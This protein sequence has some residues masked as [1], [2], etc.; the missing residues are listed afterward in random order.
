MK[1]MDLDLY[2]SIPT[3][4]FPLRV[5]LN[6]FR[7]YAFGAHW[8]EHIEIHCIFEGKAVLRCGEEVVRLEA[9]DCAVVNGNEL[10]AGLKGECSYGCLIIPPEIFGDNHV[11]FEHSIRDERLYLM[12]A[13]I[14]EEYKSFDSVRALSIM[15]NA[16]LVIS[17]LINNYSR[18]NLS[19]LGHRRYFEKLEK[20]N[21]AIRYIEDHFTDEVSTGELAEMVH[22]SEG[23]FCHLFKEVT[24]RSAK[25]YMLQL[26]INKA[27]KLIESSSNTI[28]DI[29]YSCGFSDPNYFARVFK[30]KLGCSPSAYKQG[31]L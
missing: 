17:Y 15:G 14:F 31:T 29:C 10:H 25:E 18:E 12:L 23:H 7:S 9:G 5:N 2:E 22:L 13:D 6:R 1:N 4:S 3:K 16:Y 21:K 27:K 30:K 24:G 20:V 8:H 28:T 11:L 26:R 19:E